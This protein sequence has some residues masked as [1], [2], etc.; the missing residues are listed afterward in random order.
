VAI[1][2]APAQNFELFKQIVQILILGQKK[3]LTIN[4]LNLIVAIKASLNL[5]LS[6]S[7]KKAFPNITPV[8]RP[9]VEVTG[10]L[11]PN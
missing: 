6:E 8:P 1:N 3:G 10:I 9:V 4:D 7:L 2:R 5:G 11:D